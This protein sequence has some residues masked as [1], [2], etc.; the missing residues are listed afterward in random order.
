MD[1]IHHTLY[2]PYVFLGPIK[3]IVS[4]YSQ[5]SLRGSL[6]NQT[7]LSGRFSLRLMSTKDAPVEQAA[8]RVVA[9]WNSDSRY[10]FASQGLLF[11][12]S[13]PL[14]FM[15]PL[16]SSCLLCHYLIFH[17]HICYFI[18]RGGE[19][20][21]LRDFWTWRIQVIFMSII[22]FF[23]RKRVTKEENL[24]TLCILFHRIVLL[25]DGFGFASLSALFW[26]S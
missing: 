4:W 8:Y 7:F 11:V 25:N 3:W 19:K 17:F 24:L 10:L 6:S 2:F 22:Y 14:G 26:I 1:I 23:L 15:F 13:F 20:C 16:P 12:N 9:R 18:L 5:L 21:N